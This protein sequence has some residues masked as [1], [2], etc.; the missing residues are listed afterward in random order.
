M[1]TLRVRTVRNVSVNHPLSTQQQPDASDGPRGNSPE[2]ATGRRTSPIVHAYRTPHRGKTQCRPAPHASTRT[3]PRHA[4]P[5]VIGTRPTEAAHAR[6]HAPPPCTHPRGYMFFATDVKF[7]PSEW[8]NFRAGGLRPLSRRDPPSH[9]C[10]G[11]AWSAWCFRASPLAVA[12][13]PAD[14]PRRTSA[15]RMQARQQ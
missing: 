2:R 6:R 12:P 9:F 1:A 11:R 13:T 5:A 7:E 3:P 10:E 8:D 14:H 15:P 4:R